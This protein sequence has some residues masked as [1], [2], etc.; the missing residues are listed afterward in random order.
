MRKPQQWQTAGKNLAL[1]M[2]NR[3]EEHECANEAESK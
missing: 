2:V 1:S 3:N